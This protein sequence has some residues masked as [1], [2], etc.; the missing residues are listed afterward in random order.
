MLPLA[1]W[2]C[3]CGVG[4]SGDIA[5]LHPLSLPRVRKTH[6]PVGPVVLS[7]ALFWFVMQPIVIFNFLL[8][9]VS[10]Y[11]IVNSIRRSLPRNIV[12]LVSASLN[13]AMALLEHPGAINIP[14]MG[15]YRADFAMYA[16]IFRLR[17]PPTDRTHGQP[18]QPI[19]TDAHGEPSCSRFFSADLPTFS[20][21]SE[22]EAL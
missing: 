8:S 12:P 15:D 13:E 5:F 19:L 14:N 1:D 17:V 9:S 16:H 10:L 7:V 22:L 11:G 6:N 21:R 20:V 2:S 3:A 18:S 4:I